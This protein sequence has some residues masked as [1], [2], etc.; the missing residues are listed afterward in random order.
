[1]RWFDADWQRKQQSITVPVLLRTR[2]F[3]SLLRQRR[4]RPAPYS[5]RVEAYKAMGRPKGKGH[6]EPVDAVRPQMKFTQAQRLADKNS[7]TMLKVSQLLEITH[8]PGYAE[9]DPSNLVGKYVEKLR[10]R[11]GKR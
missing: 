9:S 4:Q 11:V 3:A 7:R 5:R 6:G 2:G 1:V 8:L 10:S